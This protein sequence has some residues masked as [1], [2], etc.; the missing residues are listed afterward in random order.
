[1]ISCDLFVG[2]TSVPTG[3]RFLAMAAAH[4][5]ALQHPVHG[6]PYPAT[7]D[8]RSTSVGTLAIDSFSRP[9]CF[10]DLPVSLLPVELRR[11][12]MRAFVH[13]LDGR[14]TESEKGLKP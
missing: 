8:G 9:A 5:R 14:Y 11:S 6:G 3:E 4:S 10:Q 12:H 1:M 13:R 2:I 7:S